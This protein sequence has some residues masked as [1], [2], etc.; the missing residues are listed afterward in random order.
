MR[1]LGEIS[2]RAATA[3]LALTVLLALGAHAQQPAAA[4]QPAATP[5]PPAAAAASDSDLAKQLS[6]PLAS[7]VSVPFQFN[8]EQG[9]GPDDGTRTVLNVQPVVPFELNDD[10]NLIGRWI[11]PLVSQP[12]LTP[13]ADSTF[14]FGDVLF[15]AFFSPR[16]TKSGWTWGVGPAVSL[17]MSSDPTIGSGKWSAGP[18]VVVLKQ[19]GPWTYG[20]LANQLWSIADATKDSRPD[21]NRT[22]IQPFLAYNT[23]HGVTF[24]VQS[25]STYDHEAA[26]GEKWTV[27]VNLLVSKVSRFGPFPFSMAGGWGYFVDSPSI[28]PDRKIRIA[29]TI[30]LP[31]GK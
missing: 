15:S 1:S 5:G 31:R 2:P 9:V 14:G 30:L 21:V 7:L 4:A 26:S 23:P 13:G 12:A 11:M 8:W 6:N 10:W 18:T 29:F 16:N 20:V 28:G 27:P 25:E 22:F 3:A 24:T 17:P 19:S